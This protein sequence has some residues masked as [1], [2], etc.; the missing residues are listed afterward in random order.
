MHHLARVGIEDRDRFI[1]GRFA[2]GDTPTMA[3]I[4]LVPQ[5]FNAERFG[6]D[7]SAFP[8]VF[9][10]NANCVAETAFNSAFPDLQPDAE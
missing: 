7:L 6:C 4:C 1:G 3:D 2:H 10:I 5:V 8:T 9:Q